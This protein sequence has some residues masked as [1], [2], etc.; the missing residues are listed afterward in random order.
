MS[1]PAIP[2][3][4]IPAPVH[5]TVPT[6]AAQPAKVGDINAAPTTTAAQDVTATRQSRVNLV[7]ESV[8]AIIALSVVE[9]VLFVS[10]KICL[11]SI[12]VEAS[13]KQVAAASIAFLL[14]SNLASLIIG[15][16]FGRTNHTRTGGSGTAAHETR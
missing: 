12:G 16:Y 8:Q 2:I 10:A 14:L 4:S 7:W 13:E 1:D 15:F 6:Q 5:V 3:V 9:V 11:S